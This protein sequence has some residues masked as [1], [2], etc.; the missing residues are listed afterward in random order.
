LGSLRKQSFGPLYLSEKIFFIHFNQ[1]LLYHDA[2]EVRGSLAWGRKRANNPQRERTAHLLFISST[3]KPLWKSV[4][5]QLVSPN[6]NKERSERKSGVNLLLII[7]PKRFW[8]SYK[9]YC[10]T[11]YLP[12]K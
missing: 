3:F 11:L 1:H 4:L 9:K 5:Y 10:S 2:E 8:V 12:F 7:P 6:V